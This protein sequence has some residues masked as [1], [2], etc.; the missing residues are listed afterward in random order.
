MLG[1]SMNLFRI[2]GIQLAVH[3]SFVILLVFSAQDGWEDDGW[4][5]LLW[6]VG[7]LLAFFTCV[8]L[9]ELGHS[10]TAMHYGIGCAGSCS[11][12]SAAW[13]SSRTSRGSRCASC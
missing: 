8:V 4:A 13:R 1:W 9:H 10:F 5:G 6:G 2:R 11:C 3:F 12:P 7:T